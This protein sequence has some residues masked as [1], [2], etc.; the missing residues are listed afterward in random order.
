MIKLLIVGPNGSMGRA[1]VR[2]AVANASIELIGGVGPEGRAYIG[3]DLGFLVGLGRR[4][5]VR[6]MDSMEP[7]IDESD[8]VLECTNPEVSMAVLKTCLEHGKGFVTGTTG[9][10]AEQ[11]AEIEG[12]GDTVPVLRASN[13]SRLVHLLFDLIRMVSREAGAD[14]DIDIIEMHSRTK[15]DAPSGTAKHI[16]EIIAQELGHDLS[17]VAEYGRHGSG[18]RAPNTIQFSAIRSGGITSTHQVIFGF[19]HERLELTHRAYSTEAFA[20]GLIEAALFVAGKNRGYFTL[21]EVLAADASREMPEVVQETGSA[22]VTPIV[23]I[24]GHSGSGKTTLL[25]KLIGELKQRGYQLAVIKHHHHRGLQLDEPGKDS[26]RF[27]QA[28]ADHVVLAG[29]DRAAHLRTYSEEPSLQQVASGIRDV[30]L[31]LTEGYKHADAPK[32]E[33]SR[34]QTTLVADPDHLVAIATDRPFDVDVPR[35]DLDEV[36]RLADFIETRFLK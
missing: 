33:V 17:E 19:Q 18:V 3:R 7:L 10:S 36:N 25:E 16:G 34:G 30:D 5:G 6:V 9:F 14:A 1:L 23:S 35:F 27:T 28:G 15:R 4:V 12:A 8:V 2:S 20:E 32:I 29:P 24:V 31:I 21:Q 11:A 22:R 26:W 13:G